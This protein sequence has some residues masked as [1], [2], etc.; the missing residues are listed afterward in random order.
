MQPRPR[1][2]FHPAGDSRVARV[3]VCAGECGRND[4][5]PRPAVD[6][7]STNFHPDPTST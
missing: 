4:E 2:D 1:H 7:S 3:M 5:I 6:D